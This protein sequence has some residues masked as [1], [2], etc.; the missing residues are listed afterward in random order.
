MP[1]GRPSSSPRC[2]TPTLEAIDGQRDYD[3]V[4]TVVAQS[5]G[6]A[7]SADNV[8]T[9]VTDQLRPLGLLARADGGEPELKR[10]NPLL[11]LRFRYAVTDPERTRRITAPFAMLFNPLV[12]VPLLAAFG[13]VSWWVFFERGLAQATYQAFQ[14]PGLLILVF[15]VTVLSAG[16]HEFGHA[17]A[18]RRGGATPGV[19]GAG[20]YLV[21]PAFYTDVTDSYRLGRLG[22]VR[23]DLGGLYFNALVAVAITGVW[24]A[25]GYDA[26]LLVVAT[27]ILQMLQQ[28][29]PLVRFDGY[30][31][32]A[33]VTGVPDLFHRIKPTLLGALPWRWGDPEAR[34]LK[35]WAR[36]VV[37]AWVLIV[38]PALAFVLVMMVLALPRIIGTAWARLVQEKD[39]LATAWSDGDLVAVTAG[40]LVMLAV[41][42]PVAAI[43]Y[44]LTRLVRQVGV[45]HLADHRRP[46]RAS[47]PRGTGRARPRRRPGLGLVAR[48]RHLPADPAARARHHR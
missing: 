21:W 28:L 16:F 5:T 19:M 17:A 14:H 20:V 46:P 1:T 47:W 44:M 3:E 36:V 9:L 13:L 10:S 41:V 25:T 35:P 45:G 31:V 12:V 6:R 29:T 27:Q 23:T 42:L 40:V 24:W 33:D 2:S 37:T 11:G 43:A 39:V 15:V 26:L 38:V 30:H 32:L 48:R 7:V 22:R 18:A 8:R 4:A 34:L